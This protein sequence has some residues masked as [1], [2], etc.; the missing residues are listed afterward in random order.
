MAR[1]EIDLTT[2]Q[3]NGKMGEPTKSAWEKVND[4]T[5]E[6]YA[7]MQI[8]PGD[9]CGFK[10]TYVSP[11]SISVSSGSAALANGI[12]LYSKNSISKSGLSL[13]QFN[14]YHIYVFYSNPTTVDIEISLVEPVQ[15]FGT[16]KNKNGDTSKRYI[17]T[18][19]AGAGGSIIRF[20][21]NHESGVIK[22]TN[23]LSENNVLNLGKATT[24]TAIP[25][26][27]SIPST[28]SIGSFIMETG[29]SD[30]A[31]VSNPDI[32][33]NL[34]SSF[35]LFIRA[36]KQICVDFPVSSNRSI[37]YMLNPSTTGLSVWCTGYYFER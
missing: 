1:Q 34:S 26:S 29:E 27:N 6:L 5:A 15:Y 7:G 4:M 14:W 16:A 8:N 10:M 32:S 22:Y 9:I 19:R 3:P 13:S 20:T 24:T 30:L 28:S 17:G 18:I 21:H 37:N 2:P 33:T 36:T 25:C 12:N 23:Q 35:N 11:N 31:F